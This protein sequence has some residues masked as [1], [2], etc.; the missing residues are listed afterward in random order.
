VVSCLSFSLPLLLIGFGG[1]TLFIGTGLYSV[2]PWVASAPFAVVFLGLIVGELREYFQTVKSE[3]QTSSP[4]KTSEP[5][6]KVVLDG[7]VWIKSGKEWK[8]GWKY[9][10]ALKKDDIATIEVNADEP[11]T[12][13]LFNSTQLSKMELPFGK[14][15]F[16]ATA[17]RSQTR[18]NV[19]IS[20]Q[21]KRNGHWLVRIHHSYYIQLEVSV[22][23][24]VAS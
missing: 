2:I 8:D 22:R 15:L 5:N 11:V 13:E 24:F 21:A 7:E 6:E 9:D 10:L 19:N 3:E 20:Y 16:N 23:I 12:V 1:V 17:E 4:E 18:K 14:L